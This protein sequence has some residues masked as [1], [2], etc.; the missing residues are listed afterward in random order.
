MMQSLPN[1]LADFKPPQH[2]PDEWRD[3]NAMVADWEAAQLEA[4]KA[5]RI[6]ASGI[7]RCFLNAD[8]SK[9]CDA[10]KSWT[11][12]PGEKGLL[13]QGGVGRGKTYSACAI[14]I[15]LAG[16]HTVRF[17]AMADIL[18]QIKAT[19]SNRESEQDVIGR[20]VNVGVLVIDDVGKERF[21]EWSLP[22][23]FTI[24]DKRH[25][26]SKPTIITSQ[27]KGRALL[28]KFHVNHDMETAKALAS[29][30]GQYQRIMLEGRDLRS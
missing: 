19:F 27:Y 1:L 6:E 15:E 14:L 2:T 12:S 7:P 3:I 10:V 28:D 21:T 4:K 29:R 5:R 17:A 22:I 26:A 16:T 9:C 8:I 18:M 25:K 13:I 30:I 23:F 24:I 11:E 20:Y